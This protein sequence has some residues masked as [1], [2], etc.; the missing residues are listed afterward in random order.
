MRCVYLAGSINGIDYNSSTQWRIFLGEELTKKGYNFFDPMRGKSF[1]DKGEEPL[2][3]S[4]FSSKE[5]EFILERDLY[6][7]NQCDII[8][9]NMTFLGEQPMI[10]T[11]MELGYVL[12]AQEEID[13]YLFGVKDDYKNHPFFCKFQVHD[14]LETI[15]NIL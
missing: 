8:I 4:I 13:C 5:A 6:D 2:S 15:L 11:L 1:L 10:G 9:A 7:I 14:K 12:A 3:D